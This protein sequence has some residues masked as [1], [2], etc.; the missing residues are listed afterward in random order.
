M[1]VTYWSDYACPYCYI[2]ET[3]F[4][5]AIDSLGL[6]EEVEFEMKSFELNP[7]APR[8]VVGPTLDR[9]AAKYGLSK[10]AAATRIDGISRLGRNEGID[11]NYATTQNTNMLDAHRLTKLAHS[12][13]NTKFE[14]L[15]FEAYFVK[16]EVMA[17]H[18]VLRSIAAQAGLPTEDVERVLASDEFEAEVR[19]DENAAYA[20]GVHAVP[21]FIIDGK[22]SISGCRPTEEIAK[23]L[24]NAYDESL[25]GLSWGG[26]CGPDG[27][28]LR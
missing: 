8:E 22:Y 2:G 20:L 13:G 14:E 1:K 23:I 24:Q 17:D 25:A 12:L 18:D 27:C 4:K 7:D 3:R 15:C 28:A 11:F 21:F 10:E 16:N 19:D 5:N 26:T 6:G 9:F